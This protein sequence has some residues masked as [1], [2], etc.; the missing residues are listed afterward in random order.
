MEVN[1]RTNSFR[2]TQLPTKEYFQYDVVFRPEVPIPRKREQ[3]MHALQ[4]SIA[5]ALFHPRGVYDGKSLLYLSHPLNLPGGGGAFAVRLGNDP[6][7]PIGSPGV[8]EVLITR[9]ASEL[10]RP[11]DLNQLIARGGTIDRK[12]ATAINLLQLLIRQTSN[13]NNPTNNGRA[14]FSDIGKK[15]LQNT[16]IELW[17][18][19]FQ[20]VRP[21]IRGMIVTIDTSMAAVY[22]SGYLIDVAM[23]VL[24]ARNVRHLTLDGSQGER[25]LRKLQAHLKH[26]LIKTRTTG[27]R[28]KTI[29]ALVPGPI[30]RYKFEKDGQSITIGRYFEDAYNIKLQHPETFGVRI[31]GQNA[32]FPVIVPAEFCKV[33]PGQLYKKRLPSDRMKDVIDFTAMAPAA[34]MQTIQGVSHSGVL[35]PIQGYANSEYV[36]GAGMVVDVRPLELKARLLAHPKMDFNN[37]ELTPLNG[38]WNVVKRTFKTPVEMGLWAVVN[39]DSQ[40][41]GQPAVDKIITDL[42]RCC[43]EVG[44]TVHNPKEV[45][46]GGNAYAPERTLDAVYQAMNRKIDVIVVLLP[47]EADEIRTRVKFWGDVKYG[48]RTSCLRE[49]KLRKAND[50]YLKMVAIK[51]NARLGGHYALPR[52]VIIPQLVKGKET[53]MIFGADVAHPGISSTR[54]TETRAFHYFCLGPGTNR[55]SIASVVFS[56]DPAAA[57]YIAYSQV[58]APRLEII[59]DLQ[60]MVKKAILFFGRD[61]QPPKRIIFYRDGVSEGE[62]EA[63]KLVEVAA[64]RK[65][66][67]EIWEEK[68][69]PAPLP[70]LSFISVAKR[71]HTIFTPLDNRVD[72]GKTGNCLAGL[73]VDKLRSPVAPDFYLQ[74]HGAIKG[75]S[76]SAHYS[77]LFD[78]NFKEDLHTHTTLAFELCHLYAKATRSISLPAPV[79]Y[80]DMVCAR[81]KF[82]FENIDFDATTNVSGPEELDLDFW[83]QAYRPVS[84][85]LVRDAGQIVPYDETMYFL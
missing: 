52:S 54:S 76:R 50:Q 71:H 29:H 67:L 12:A 34:R 20:S 35:S 15:S 47:K 72:D 79:Y 61:K 1:V 16:G 75:T 59:D 13:Q 66:C 19:F 28:T 43:R 32:P 70:T 62:M 8:F 56:C 46:Y 26:R 57:K 85:A 74:A 53:F 36:T 11:M 38:S 84:T 3:A 51:L 40:H 77:I 82:H 5:P 64:I 4:N 83:K 17:R 65:A 73:V 14:F 9:T 31:S 81:G 55:P 18:G 41:I 27:E 39:F 10:V 45:N 24:N 30:G 68:R 44:M 48:V 37:S 78:E 33:L 60:G 6:N 21:T 25:D 69:P 42:L 63:V 58:Q 22:E 23:H 7:A 80:A 49:D 2:I